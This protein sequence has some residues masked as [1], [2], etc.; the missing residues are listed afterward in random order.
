MPPCV[1]TGGAQQTAPRGEEQRQRAK[2]PGFPTNVRTKKKHV[3]LSRANGDIMGKSWVYF[4]E[5]WTY[6]QQYYGFGCV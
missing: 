4:H 3:D 2:P 5:I 6:K 1:R